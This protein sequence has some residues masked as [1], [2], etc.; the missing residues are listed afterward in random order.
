MRVWAVVALLALWASTASASVKLFTSSSVP[1]GWRRS[2]AADLA[3]P[4]HFHVALQQE[5]LDQLDRI[6][7]EVSDPQHANYQQFLSPDEILSLVKPKEHKRQ[8]VFDWLAASGVEQI[9]DFIDSV[10]VWTTVEIASKMFECPF[11]SYV[12]QETG[13][14][15]VKAAGSVFVPEQV[16]DAIDSVLGLATF[17]VPHYSSHRVIERSD[18]VLVAE[19]D[20]IIPQT[21]WSLYSMPNQTVAGLSA[22]SQGVIEWEGQSFDPKDLD[23]YSN[24]TGIKFPAVPANHIIGPNVPR[25][26]GDEA[27]LDI[28]FLAAINPGGQNWFWIEGGQIW[29]YGF[30]VHFVNTTQVPD[31]ISVSYGWWEGD[32]CQEG[33]GA[34]ECQKLGV[35]T[36]GYVARVNT[37]FQKIGVRGVSTFVSSGDS[38][39]HTRSD[40]LCSQKRTL[41]D[42]PGSSPYITS[43]GATQVESE[44]FFAPSIAPV[45]ANKMYNYSCVMT[46][47]EVA[48]NVSRSY[49]TSGGGFSNISRRF[50]YQEAAVSAYLKQT[51]KLPPT[52]YFNHTGRAYPDVSAVGHNGFILDGGNAVLIG[53]TSQSAPTFAAVAAA[54]ADTFKS[55]T[56]KSFGFMNPLIYQAYASDKSCFIDITVGDNICTE[57]GCSK[58]CTGYTAAPGWDGVT[59]LGSPNFACLSAYI[60]ELA[61]RVVATRAAKASQDLYAASF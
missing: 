61:D 5:N 14:S 44:T 23:L 1:T 41:A 33:I 34:E 30:A 39:A 43:V 19:N 40:G 25:Q 24:A 26:P 27:S 22:I 55:K 11:Y 18:K 20:A 59:G 47:R 37:E 31:V 57:N 48:V 45:C 7:W 12:H 42:F 17:P 16:Y 15:I 8:A 56:G 36:E 3:S 58:T 52:D 13:K 60:N 28:Q 35:K 51:D 50:A 10:E 4:V 38:G 53:G 21:I 2:T 6:F 54:L 9:A 32:Q 29:L 46:G 49:F